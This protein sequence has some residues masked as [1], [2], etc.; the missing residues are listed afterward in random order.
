[1]LLGDTNGVTEGTGRHRASTMDHKTLEKYL[2]R[3]SGL[4]LYLR[5]MDEA[6]YARLCAVCTLRSTHLSLP[7]LSMSCDQA[8]FSAASELHNTQMQALFTAYAT[9][10]K[11]PVEDDSGGGNILRSKLHDTK[12]VYRFYCPSNRTCSED[13]IKK[14]G[15][16]CPK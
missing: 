3:Y 5:E 4:I 2:G 10:V 15:H 14:S 8:Y 11:K 1:M 9:A 6:T 7:T 12:L 13:G 16:D